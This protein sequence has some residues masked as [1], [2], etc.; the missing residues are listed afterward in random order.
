MLSAIIQ[1]QRDKYYISLIKGF[2]RSKFIEKESRMI[3][4]RGFRER[5]VNGYI[6][7]V[8][9]NKKCSRDGQC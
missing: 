5:T 7:S 4:T 8:W 1:L 3:F 6:V 9:D 2:I